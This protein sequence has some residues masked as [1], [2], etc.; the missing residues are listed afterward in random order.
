[1]SFSPNEMPEMTGEPDPAKPI[2]GSPDFTTPEE[3]EARR[4]KAQAQNE[5]DLEFQAE[6]RRIA[7]QRERFAKERV[8]LTHGIQHNIVKV[9][10]VPKLVHLLVAKTLVAGTDRYDLT[11]VGFYSSRENLAEHIGPAAVKYAEIGGAVG[12]IDF[13]LTLVQDA[14]PR[15]P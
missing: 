1:M 7:E 2:G 5:A 12:I 14:P 4:L 3:R 10:A 8:R 6:Q 15:E 11:V 13:D 9:P